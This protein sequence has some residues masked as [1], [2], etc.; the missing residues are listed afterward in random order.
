MQYL[1]DQI[2]GALS[3]AALRFPSSAQIFPPVSRATPGD[4]PGFLSGAGGHVLSGV[5]AISTQESDI[6]CRLRSSPALPPAPLGSAQGTNRELLR[7]KQ[8]HKSKSICWPAGHICQIRELS[9]GEL[10]SL[11]G[12][13]EV[14]FQ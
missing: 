8:T 9:A 3:A 11:H 14:I 6:T 2:V 7:R 10:P 13:G 4:N 12:I 5:P 1:R